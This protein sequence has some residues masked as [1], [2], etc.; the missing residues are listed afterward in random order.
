MKYIIVIS[1]FLN[2]QKIFLNVKMSI[3]SILKEKNANL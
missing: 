2:V 3:G 1:D